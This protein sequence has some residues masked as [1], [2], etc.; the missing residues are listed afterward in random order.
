MIIVESLGPKLL[1]ILTI[2]THLLI[3]LGILKTFFNSLKK[4]S[5]AIPI[6]PFD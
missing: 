4:M 6:K 5:G 3:S 2:H 1:R